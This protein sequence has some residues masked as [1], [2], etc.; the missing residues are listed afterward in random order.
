MVEIDSE[1]SMILDS[2][3]SLDKREKQE[4]HKEIDDRVTHMRHRK[5]VEDNIK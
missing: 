1:G 4:K 3:G 2:P 5:N